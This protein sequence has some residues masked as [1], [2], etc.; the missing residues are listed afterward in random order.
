[1]RY[2]MTLGSASAKA[3]TAIQFRVMCIID[4][5]TNGAAATVLDILETN[6]ILSYNNLA[7]RKRFVTLLDHQGTLNSLAGGGN[8]TAEDYAARSEYFQKSLTVNIPME[9]DSTTGILSEIQ[10]NNILWLYIA[11]RTIGTFEMETRIRFVDGK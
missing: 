1:M 4:K 9:F 10:S 5:Q 2:N 3:D 8:G 11:N 6:T 7:N